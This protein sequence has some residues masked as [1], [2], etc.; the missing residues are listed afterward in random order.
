MSHGR[1]SI[2]LWAVHH[3]VVKWRPQR[4]HFENTSQAA[5][6]TF[7]GWER[8]VSTDRCGSGQRARE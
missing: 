1:L 7:S 5:V 8:G 4:R 3:M 6:I 2:T